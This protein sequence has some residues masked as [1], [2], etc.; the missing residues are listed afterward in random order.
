MMKDLTFMAKTA[1]VETKMIKG[2]GTR[3]GS[4]SSYKVSNCIRLF[5]CLYVNRS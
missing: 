3:V 1:D 5:E 4:G 2:H